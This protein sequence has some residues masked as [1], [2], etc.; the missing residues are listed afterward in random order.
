[1]SLCDSCGAEARFFISDGKGKGIARYCLDCH[2]KMMTE[3]YYIELPE[4]IPDRLWVVDD[5]GVER[6]FDIEFIL[7]GHANK[8]EAN[9]RGVSKYR[10]VVFGEPDEPFSLLWNELVQRITKSINTKYLS[11]DKWPV[12]SKMVGY[13]EYNSETESC[14]LIIDGHNLDMD[15]L[16]R[17][18]SGHEGFQIKVEFADATDDIE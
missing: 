2:N 11:E 15:E 7:F 8:L 9:E 14:D 3:T 17:V 6:C 4:S 5:Q 1:M 12:H 13:I 10:C 18:I 16:Q